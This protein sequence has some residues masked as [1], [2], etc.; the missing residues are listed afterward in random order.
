M[1]IRD[2]DNPEED[3]TDCYYWDNRRDC[4]NHCRGAG[5]L[6]AGSAMGLG[7]EP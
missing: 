7:T 6:E 2:A 3:Q 1:I 5:P 4:K